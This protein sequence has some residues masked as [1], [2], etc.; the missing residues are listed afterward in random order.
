MY[1][2]DPDSE[3]IQMGWVNVNDPFVQQMAL[4]TT[5]TDEDGPDKTS[6]C[7]F[8]AYDQFRPVPDAEDTE[9]SVADELESDVDESATTNV[10]TEEARA[11]KRGKRE[12]A[13][14]CGGPMHFQFPQRDPNQLLQELA[15][16]PCENG[17][18]KVG[19]ITSYESSGTEFTLAKR[20]PLHMQV[21]GPDSPLP[22][23]FTIVKLWYDGT[24]RVAMASIEAT[25]HKNL[26]ITLPATMVQLRHSDYLWKVS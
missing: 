21:Q 3:E 10:T 1:F 24:E 18:L 11:P 16:V 12:P 19:S 13:P 23:E 14:V 15:Y 5:G 2:S 25:A 8:V 22:N 6:H 20:L 7:Q 17:I 26:K 9:A 4:W